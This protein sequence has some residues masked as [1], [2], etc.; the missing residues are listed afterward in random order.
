MH[1]TEEF[2]IK[3]DRVRRYLN[4]KDL[5]G[6]VLSRADNFA[7]VGCGADSLVDNSSETGVGTLVVT[8]DS[9]VLVTNNI[10]SD[11]L[12]TEELTG[13]EIDDARTYP[14]H[15]PSERAEILAEL[16]EDGQF[17][18]DDGCAG[19]PRLGGDFA[20]LRYELTEAEVER[21]RALGS[22]TSAAVEHAVGD[23]ESGMTEAQAASLLAGACRRRGVVPIVMLVAAD[24]RVRK[25]RHP[26]PFDG[27]AQEYMML[28]VC[29]RRQ[30]L[31]AAMTRLVHFGDVPEE[32]ARR[33]RAVC[34][35]DAALISSTRPGATASEVLSAGQDAYEATGFHN[36]WRHHHQGGAIGYQGR[37]YKA[38]PGCREEVREPQA[39]AWNPSISGTKSEDTILVTGHGTEVLTAASDDWP[40]VTVEVQGQEMQRPDILVK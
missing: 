23:I 38:T 22:D 31:I 7:W 10:E 11:R 3:L 6:V 26:V 14:W 24:D 39:F 34:T 12:L 25:W 27:L 30:G 29:G 19:L 20:R 15:R 35:V 8:L 5:D 40:M 37:E 36:E 13:L 18:A 2:A 21:Y 16:T 17:V 9:V 28:A 32:L 1:R 33:H 4:R